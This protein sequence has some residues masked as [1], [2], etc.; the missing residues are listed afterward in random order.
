MK[1]WSEHFKSIS[2]AKTSFGAD[3]ITPLPG[4]IKVTSQSQNSAIGWYALG[5]AV[6]LWAAW[7]IGVKKLTQEKNR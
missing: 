7:E 4:D 2:S 6:M 1:T 5:G 3:A